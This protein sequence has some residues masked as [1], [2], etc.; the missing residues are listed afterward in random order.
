MSEEE[1]REWQTLQDEMDK[2]E[3]NDEE[4]ED[5]GEGEKEEGEGM[6]DDDDE[7]ERVHLDDE[8]I[9]D[10]ERELDESETELSPLSVVERR[11]ACVMLSKVRQFSVAIQQLTCHF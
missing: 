5:I 3:D 11:Q 6:I 10:L 2:Y 4:D 8:I 1:A 7:R 9:T